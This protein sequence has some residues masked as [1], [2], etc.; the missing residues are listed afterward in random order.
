MLG[1]LPIRVSGGE[2]A[3]RR[4][5]DAL[6]GH[7]ASASMRLHASVTWVEAL[8]T[9]AGFGF[10]IWLLSRSLAQPAD[11]GIV[12]LLV[13]WALSL[14]QL[15]HQVALQLR[16]VP[17]FRSLAVRVLEPFQVSMAEESLIRGATNDESL[18][19]KGVEALRRLEERSGVS[20][21]LR[22]IHLQI[23][24]Q[25][26]LEGIN[27]SIEAGDHIAIVGP[28]GAGKSSL[29]GL[30]LGF[31]PPSRGRVLLDG[32]P[33]DGGQIAALRR[34]TVWIDPAVH[35]FNRSLVSNLSYATRFSEP[36]AWEQ[37]IAD[38][39]LRSVLEKLP[40]GLQ[41]RLGEG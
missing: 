2:Q 33:L 13:Y 7:W 35:L 22:E 6:L 32:Q 27:L 26:I 1:L 24:G 3:M 39:N 30:L 12:L 21:E 31:N 19:S 11:G 18:P 9:L 28:S 23:G 16:Q 8:Q 41:T 36:I 15:G 37:V 10:A 25:A 17:H 4:E 38:C 29:L 14:T 40:E 34:H 20:L 5:H